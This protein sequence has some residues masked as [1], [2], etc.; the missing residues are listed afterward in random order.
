MIANDFNDKDLLT[1]IAYQTRHIRQVIV[2]L[3]IGAFVLQKQFAHVA[4]SV[5]GPVYGVRYSNKTA[6]ECMNSTSKKIQK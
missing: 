5:F 1:S 6:T 3:M 2:Q 4:W